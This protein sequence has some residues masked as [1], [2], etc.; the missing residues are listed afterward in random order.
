M[1]K[2][3]LPR[4]LRLEVTAHFDQLGVFRLLS[5]IPDKKTRDLGQFT[6]LARDLAA[7][8]IASLRFDY[9]GEG[10]VLVLV[11][12]A[13]HAARERPVLALE[14]D[15]PPVADPAPSPPEGSEMY[16]VRSGLRKM[17][18]GA[19]GDGVCSASHRVGGASGS[20]SLV[21]TLP[22]AT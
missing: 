20:T 18:F 19:S 1:S 17:Y 3:C 7:S 10:G 4:R 13:L 22:D 11:T 12:F 15:L 16:D 14:P 21:M 2:E 9:R 5:L 8:G 6:L